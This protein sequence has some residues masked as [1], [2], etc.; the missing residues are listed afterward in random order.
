MICQRRMFPVARIQTVIGRGFR[1]ACNAEQRTEGVERVEAP[2]K[3]ERELIQIGLQMLR[4]D[5]VMRSLQPRFEI[6]H[7][8]RR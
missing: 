8:R 5:T 4:A 1:V 3:A 7:A 6:R 2:V